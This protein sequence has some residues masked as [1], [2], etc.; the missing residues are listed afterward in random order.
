MKRTGLLVVLVGCAGLAAGFWLRGRPQAAPAATE[1]AK[2]QLIQAAMAPEAGEKVVHTFADQAAMQAFVDLWQQRQQRALRMAMLEGYW[3]N[4]QATLED[5]NNRLTSQYGLD[6]SKGYALNSDER[7]LIERETPAATEQE[8]GTPETA[9]AAEGTAAG[10]AAAEPASEARKVVHTF[11]DDAAMEAF[12][13]LWQQRQSMV[14]RMAVLKAY[15][16]SE[17]QLLNQLND[18]L[19]ATYQVDVAKRYTLNNQR[20]VLIE[21]PAPPAPQEAATP[22]PQE[23]AA[24]APQTPAPSGAPTTSN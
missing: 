23:A 17:Q 18:S 14:V 5:L 16:D 2:A 21:R 12:A 22:T 7:V 19:S 13:Q 20:L 11:A 24:P 6:L 10:E 1:D 15:W 3:N 4:E 8:P 9:P